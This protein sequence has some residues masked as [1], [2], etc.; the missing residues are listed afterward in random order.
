M[1][2]LLQLPNPL[3]HS[4]KKRKCKLN[5]LMNSFKNY[6]TNFDIYFFEQILPSVECCPQA[7]SSIKE[8]KG[9]RLR[10]L[11]IIMILMLKTLILRSF[12]CLC[13]LSVHIIFLGSCFHFLSSGSKTISFIVTFGSVNQ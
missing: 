8:E 13:Y 1:L 11:T 10:L 3:R 5:F 9:I 6:G 7:R 12:N 4:L 2:P